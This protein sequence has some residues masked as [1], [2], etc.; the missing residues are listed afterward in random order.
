MIERRHEE[1]R[2]SQQ[3]LVA[4]AHYVCPSCPF[5]GDEESMIE[6]AQII[7]HVAIIQHTNRDLV[8]VPVGEPHDHELDRMMDEGC[9]NG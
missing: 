9:P 6:H 3:G 8:L 5:E 1:R 7:G 4:S 2:Q